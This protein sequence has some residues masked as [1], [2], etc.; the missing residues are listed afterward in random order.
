MKFDGMGDG[1]YALVSNIETMHSPTLVTSL[2]LRSRF[3]YCEM[4]LQRSCGPHL[5]NPPLIRACLVSWVKGLAT[6][7]ERP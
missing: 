6:V 2:L 7:L 5:H 1:D 4:I 3:I